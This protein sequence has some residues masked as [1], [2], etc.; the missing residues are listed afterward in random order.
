M[1]LQFLVFAFNSLI[2]D[3]PNGLHNLGVPGRCYQNLQAYYS[4]TPLR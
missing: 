1:Q 3:K 4:L 2:W